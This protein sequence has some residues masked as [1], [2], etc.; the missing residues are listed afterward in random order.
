MPK[1][2]L[3]DILIKDFTMISDLKDKM[4]SLKNQLIFANVPNYTLML[5]SN[6]LEIRTFRFGETIIAQDE[7]PKFFYILLEGECKTAYECVILKEKQLF[8]PAT[9]K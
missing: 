3:K 8:L 7:A 4:S 6:M 9:E 5:L 2:R 1:D